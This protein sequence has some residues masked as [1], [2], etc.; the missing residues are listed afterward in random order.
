MKG[1]REGQSGSQIKKGQAKKGGIRV[2][3]QFAHAAR[4]AYAG[5]PRRL[6][7]VGKR[8]GEAIRPSPALPAPQSTDGEMWEDYRVFKA[9]GMLAAWR[10]KWGAHLS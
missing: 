2:S 10:M 9:A 7:A 5:K 8:K 6:R 3:P 1:D 4:A